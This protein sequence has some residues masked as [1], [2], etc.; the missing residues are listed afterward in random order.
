MADIPGCV[1]G[2][3]VINM[4]T[5][6]VELDRVKGLV[7]LKKWILYYMEREKKIFLSQMLSPYCNCI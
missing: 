3:C 1:N 2:Q 6:L 7:Q 4:E 5:V